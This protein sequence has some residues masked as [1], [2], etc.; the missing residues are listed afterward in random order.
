MDIL[1][2]RNQQWAYKAPV[3]MLSIAKTNFTRNNKPNRHAFHDV[4]LAMGNLIIQATASG[5]YVHQMAG[6][7]REKA[8]ESLQIP[9]GY[10]PVAM[11]AIGY[12]GDPDDLPELFKSRENAPRTRKTLEEIVYVGKWDKEK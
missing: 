6:F 7:D 4:G 1:S 10:E 3:L 11:A 8:R 2:E 5:L 12:L 9:D